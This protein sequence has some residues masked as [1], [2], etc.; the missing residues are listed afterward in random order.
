MSQPERP[1]GVF[2]ARLEATANAAIVLTC[3]MAI[4]VV[5]ARF[6]GNRHSSDSE[7]KAKGVLTTGETLPISVVDTAFLRQADE[8]LLI[9]GKSECTFCKASAPF[10]ERLSHDIRAT[11]SGRMQLGWLTTDTVGTA[12]E[13]LR[14]TNTL[15]AH[16]FTISQDQ[17]RLLRLP[18]TPSLVLVNSRGTVQRVW[19]GALD[20]S[21]EQEVRQLVLGHT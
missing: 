6:I 18:G 17:S 21:H 11:S 2:A 9:Y 20:E 12:E 10:Y 13:Y 16:T 5:A 8:T 1:R 19:V 15:V 3:A 14:L 4:A 7:L